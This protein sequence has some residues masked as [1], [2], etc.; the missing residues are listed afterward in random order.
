M[1]NLIKENKIDYLINKKGEKLLP[2]QYYNEFNYISIPMVGKQTLIPGWQNKK[3]TVV[4]HY[5]GSNI[6]LLTGKI[7]NLTILDIDIKDDGMLY[8]NKI[9]KEYPY[10]KTPT[11][12]SPGGSIHFYFKFNYKI[13][14]MNRILINNKRIGWDLKS[15]GSIITSPPSLYPD[16]RKRYKWLSGLSLNECKPIDM[17]KWLE[18]FILSHLKESTIKRIQK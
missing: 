1:S 8:W 14:N 10:F 4:P 18:N 3:E 17:P 7:N 11:V 5:L 12:K 15:N 2:W 16:T 9:K 13:P 6:G